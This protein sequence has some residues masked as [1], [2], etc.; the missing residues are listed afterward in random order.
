[1]KKNEVKNNRDSD[2][3]V[4]ILEPVDVPTEQGTDADRQPT[5]TADESKENT[6]LRLLKHDTRLA[7]VIVDVLAG[8]NAEESISTYFPP[9]ATEQSTLEAQLAEA[10]QRGYLRGRN[11]TVKLEMNERPLWNSDEKPAEQERPNLSIPSI[12]SRIKR[13]VWDK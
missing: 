2:E 5:E 8:K 10:E 9:K 13:S 3:K 12:L 1:M 6:L 4:E 7:H 11:E